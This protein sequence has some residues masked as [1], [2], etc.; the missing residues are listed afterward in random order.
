MTKIIIANTTN[1]C[2]ERQEEEKGD[3]KMGT[4]GFNK[5]NLWSPAVLKF[6]LLRYSQEGEP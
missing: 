6:S 5:V 4:C 1:L 2:F 3:R